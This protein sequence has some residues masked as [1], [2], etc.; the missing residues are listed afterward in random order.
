MLYKYKDAFSARNEI[1]T[2]PKIEVEIDVTDISIFFIRPYHIKEGDQ[3]ILDRE[4][5]GLCYLG[6]LKKGFWH[7]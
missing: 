1:G 7:I 5:K 4:M 2:W 3:N 6:I